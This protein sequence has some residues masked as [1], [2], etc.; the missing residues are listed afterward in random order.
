MNATAGYFSLSV[1]PGF[2]LFPPMP[3]PVYLALKQLF[4]TGRVSFFTVLSVLGVAVGVCILLVATSIMGGFGHEIKRMTVETQGEIVVKGRQPIGDLTPYQQVLDAMPEIA[5]WTPFAQGFTMLEYER[6]PSF[7]TVTGVEVERFQKT[8][9]LQRY[10]IAGSFDDLDDDSIIVSSIL[11]YNLG[12][13]VGGTVSLYSP[14]MLD[15]IKKDEVFLPREVRV[16]GVFEIGHQHL[17]S[18][19]VYCSLRL[20]QDLYGLE[21]AVHGF[22]VRLKSG[23]DADVVAA[24]LNAQLPPGGRA[25]TWF[26]VSRDM[27]SIIAFERNMMAFLLMFIVIVAAFAITVSLMTQVVR[28]TREIGLLAAMGGSARGVAG[29]YCFE[30]L[31]IGVCGTAGGLALGFLVLHYRDAIVRLLNKLF[32]GPDVF[33]KFYQFTK[34]P[35]N[36]E[37]KDIVIITVFALVASALA[38]LIPA[39]RAARL[40]PVEALRSE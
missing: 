5:A 20:M 24:K 9:P 40:K 30:G 15:R 18:S 13:E 34:L 6:R 26:E 35:A 16:A 23:A 10:L 2:R 33:E 31:F 21:Q 32:L 37:A 8:I 25:H 39:W 22:N 17:D 1:A 19:T 4:P 14:L 38:G 11:A 3:W 28:K 12:I 36:T 27:Q 29:C 7:P